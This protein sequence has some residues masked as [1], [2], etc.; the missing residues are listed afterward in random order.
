M[1]NFRLSRAL[2]ACAVVAFALNSASS[3]TAEPRFSNYEIRVIRPRYVTKTGHLE[4]A[5][6]LATIVNQTFVYTVLATGLL[7][8]HFS[9]VMAAEVEGGYG[10][11][12]DRDDKRR[13]NDDFNIK[14]VVLRPES[15]GN[16]RVVWTPSYG[17]FHLTASRIV[18]FDTSV[19]A[20]FGTTGVRYQYD[21][22]DGARAAMVKQDQTVVLGLGQRYFVDQHSSIRVGL[23]FQRVLTDQADASCQQDAPHEANSI[24]NLLFYMGWS[25]YL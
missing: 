2:A 11:S 25:Y 1:P 14:T 3:A 4:I 7:T 10:K 6:G 9:E 18:Y 12:I 15:L 23:D 5:G 16:A 20:G 22:C 24:N 13:L 8:W 17:K 19:A 21:H